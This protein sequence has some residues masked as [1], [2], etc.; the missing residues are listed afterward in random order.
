MLNNALSEARSQLNSRSTKG[1]RSIKFEAKLAYF[2]KIWGGT[3]T[4]DPFT[5]DSTAE[6]KLDGRS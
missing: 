6:A 4:L 3:P 2:I 5:L 1:N